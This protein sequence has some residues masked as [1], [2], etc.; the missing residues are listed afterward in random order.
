VSAPAIRSGS[1]L[2]SSRAPARFAS[3]E[4]TLRHQHDEREMGVSECAR[5]TPAAWRRKGQPRGLETSVGAVR[6]VRL[7]GRRRRIEAATDDGDA[8]RGFRPPPSDLRIDRPISVDRRAQAATGK[9]PCYQL[10]TGRVQRDCDSRVS[11][12]ERARNGLRRTR[13]GG[14]DRD[15]APRLPLQLGA[16]G[17]GS[18]RCRAGREAEKRKDKPDG[19]R[20]SSHGVNTTTETL[21]A[22]PHAQYAPAT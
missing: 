17:S 11:V 14:G 2:P 12:I 1:Q 6:D 22:V 5:D 15:L 20:P 19:Q 3:R 9:A 21:S 4:T 7:E 18:S 8:R 10:A 16:R 13:T